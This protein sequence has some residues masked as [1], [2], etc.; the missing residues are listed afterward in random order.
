MKPEQK[1]EF[2]SLLMETDVKIDGIDF[3]NEPKE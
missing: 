1:Q 3:N 2:L